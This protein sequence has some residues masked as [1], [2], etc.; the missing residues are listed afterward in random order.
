MN[1]L[2]HHRGQLSVYLRLLDVPVPSM[3]GPSADEADLLT[4]SL[5]Q[6]SVAG[7]VAFVLLATAN[8]AGLPLR[9]LRPGV[10]HPGRRPRARPGA[11]SARRRA[12]RRTRPPD[13]RR[14]GAGRP[15]ARHRAVARDAVPRRLPASSLALIWAGL[16]LIGTRVYRSPW[17][18]AALARGLHAAPSHPAHQRQLVRA[19]LPSADAGVRRRHCSRSPRCCAAARGSP[20]ALVARRP[21]SSTSRPPSG[22]RCSSASALAVLDRAAAA[23][24]P[25]PAARCAAS[26]SSWAATAGRSAARLD[27]DGRGVAAGGGQQGFALRRRSGRCGRGLANLGFLGLLWWAHRR[28][29]APRRRDAPRIAALVWGATALVGALPGDAAAR[30]PPACRWRCS[31]RSR[32][33]S[34]WSTSSR[35]STCVAA[36]LAEAAPDRHGARGPSVAGRSCCAAAVRHRPRR[37]RH[38]GRAPGTCAVRGAPARRRRGR[39]RC[40]WMRAPAARRARPRRSRARMEVRDERARVGRTRRAAR[41]SEGLGAGDLLA[42][43]RRRGSSSA[44]RRSATSRADGRTRARRSRARYD[45]DYLVT[46]ADLPLPVAYRNEQFRIYSLR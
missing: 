40:E 36:R 27:D 14:R 41:G 3:Y 25:S 11:L 37:L 31:S 28:A 22:S 18:V 34:G 13:G 46:E 33:S 5:R 38:A 30:S 6:L 45:L 39:T 26:C 8:G 1:H 42:R 12:H 35:S 29:R 32:A 7:G 9:R 20:V 16:V 24:R 2:V 19:V 23:R 4:R 43:R 15:R 44:R 17:A 21:P 10:L